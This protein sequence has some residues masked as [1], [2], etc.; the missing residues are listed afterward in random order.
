[1]KTAGLF[2]IITIFL[3][4]FTP[5]SIGAGAHASAKNILDRIDDLYRGKSSHAKMSMKVVTSHYTREMIM[6]EWT[7]GKD[8]SLVRILSP[9]K[10]RGT[11]TLKAGKDIWNYLPKIK[12]VIKIPSSMMSRSW[13][14]SHFTNDDLVKE[15]R[16]ADDYNYSITFEGKRNGKDII[17]L[18]LDPKPDAAVVWGKVV[19]VVDKK[20]MLP[21]FA[22]YLDED[23]K[24][25]RTMYFSNVKIL[26]KRKIP[27]T[28]KVVPADKPNEYTEFS[29]LN[30]DFDVNLDRNFFSIRNLKK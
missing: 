2:I 11:A 25:A 19:I 9:R 4:A 21:V 26:G 10:D 29:V 23:M 28:M 14:G 30:I 5:A 3:T 6:E 24:L 15:S 7:R 12:R 8:F 13:M 20:D 27:S 1:M 18:T 17:E 22:R 16:M